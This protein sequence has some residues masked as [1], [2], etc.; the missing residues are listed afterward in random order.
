VDKINKSLIVIDK[1]GDQSSET[2]LVIDKPLSV[3]DKERVMQ[4]DRRSG[5]KSSSSGNPSGGPFSADRYVIDENV[6]FPDLM[7]LPPEGRP[8]LITDMTGLEEV[9]Q[10][11]TSRFGTVRLFRRAKESGDFEYFAA[12]F[13][14]VGENRE[15]T[16]GFDDRMRAL[17]GLWHPYVMPI[18]GVILPQKN[19]GSIILTP[20][21]ENGSLADILERVSRNDPPPFWNDTTTLRMIVSLITGLNYLHNKGIVHRE[22]KPTDLIVESDGSLLICDY[23]TCV[24]EEHRFAR[25]SQVGG[26]SFVAP[27][28]YGDEHD[29]L[30]LRDPKTDVFTFGL[31]LY[32]ILCGQPVFPSTL[33]GAVVIRRATSTRASDRPLIPDSL[34]PILRELI[35]RS[36]VPPATKRPSLETLWKRMRSVRFK[37]FPSVEVD[38]VAQSA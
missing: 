34:H 23:A 19:L 27:E 21:N 28:I 15:G 24:L 4:T 5:E 6:L 16:F 22:L 25:A 8:A 10:L 3:E 29:G 2:G 20:F 17:L 9:R 1:V 7:T 38:F 11:G 14:I 30:K 13:Y 32:A 36:W 18:V 12:K 35:T 31:I 26:P 33:S 37:F